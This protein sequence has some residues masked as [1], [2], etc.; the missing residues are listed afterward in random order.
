[1]NYKNKIT[2]KTKVSWIAEYRISRAGSKR[3][4]NPDNLSC[5]P[6]DR[7]IMA[8]LYIDLEEIRNTQ[9]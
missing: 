7:P 6:T 2:T 5:M 8:G 3:D 9:G 1:M 4:L